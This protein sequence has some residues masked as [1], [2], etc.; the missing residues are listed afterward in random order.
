M[1][2]NI[3]I[4][5]SWEPKKRDTILASTH[6]Y[7]T[8]SRLCSLLKWE[9]DH[10]VFSVLCCSSVVAQNR[11]QLAAHGLEH[12]PVAGIWVFWLKE[13]ADLSSFR[14]S[15]KIS[16]CLMSLKIALKTD[17]FLPASKGNVSRTCPREKHPFPRTFLEH[18]PSVSIKPKSCFINKQ[19]PGPLPPD[20]VLM[21]QAPFLPLFSCLGAQEWFAR[22]R[23][24]LQIVLHQNPGQCRFGDRGCRT[25]CC[26]WSRSS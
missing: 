19:N 22:N 24:P 16:M 1:G 20:P 4:Y 5:I 2:E 23:S 10:I 25:E 12:H 17:T 21:C 14:W 13:V 7:L 3:E 26:I 8:M 18:S 6:C 15:G 11:L 9:N